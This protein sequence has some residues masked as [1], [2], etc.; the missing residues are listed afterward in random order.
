[1]KRA[2]EYHYT[3]SFED[4]NLVGNVY[5][6]NH[7]RWQGRC[8]EMFLLDNAPSIVRQFQ[9]GLAIV[10]TRCSCEYFSELYAFDRLVI[11]M[12]LEDLTQSRISLSFEYWRKG[13]AGEELIARGEQQV[14]CMMR[15][16][17]HMEPVPVPQDLRTALKQY[18]YD[19]KDS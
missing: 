4:T 6:A 3:V 8:R 19:R 1:M 17:E 5:Y 18:E 9:E 12:R 7:I 2:Y 11:R 13:R 10:T 15:K 14:A 16:G